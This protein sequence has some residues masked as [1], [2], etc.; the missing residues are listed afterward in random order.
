MKKHPRTSGL[1][2]REALDGAAAATAVA[3]TP[4]GTPAPGDSGPLDTGTRPP[5]IDTVIMVMMENRSFDHWLGARRLLEGRT[6]EDGLD[7][8]ME[9]PD[10]DG[11]AIRPFRADTMCL[12]DPPHGWDSSRAQFAGGENSGFCLE[13][14]ERTGGD[15]AGV[16]GY[17]T[18]EELPV[19]WALADAFGVCDRY[20][21]SVMGPTWPN[22]LYGHAASSQGMISNEFPDGH[23]YSATTIWQKVAEAGLDW[24]FY[25]S[26]VPFIALFKDHFDPDHVKPVEDFFTAAAEGTL[27]PVVWVDPAF[28]YNDNHPPHHPGLG[29]LFLASVYEALAASPQWDRTLLLITFDEHGGFFDH[30]PPPMTEDDYAD[31]GFNQLGFRVPSLVIGPWVKQGVLSDVLDHT[32]WLKYLCEK[33]GIEPWNTRIAAATSLGV[34]L[35]EAR[36]AS[37]EPLEAPA[38]PAFDFDPNDVGQECFYGPPPPAVPAHIARFAD[39]ARSR[40]F[41]VRLDRDELAALFGRE[42]RRRGLIG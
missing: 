6:D 30:V 37:G 20:F 42:A 9:N 36:M 7:E 19:T 22:R 31:D 39:Y 27:P 41:P 16:M 5:G 34:V 11:N 28:L 40:G 4:R 3:C 10:P 14:A 2:R 15:G 21:C 32:S 24:A 29:E 13:Y 26:D 1:S 38:L 18:R 25:Y 12:S 35:D 8:D 23:P 17:L 33:H